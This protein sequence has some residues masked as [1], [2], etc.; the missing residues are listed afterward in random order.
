MYQGSLGAFIGFGLIVGIC[1]LFFFDP[2]SEKK[3]PTEEPGSSLNEYEKDA[4]VLD[5]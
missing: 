1:V 2:G 4:K 3:K 5:L